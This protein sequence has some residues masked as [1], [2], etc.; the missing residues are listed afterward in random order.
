MDRF[1]VLKHY[2]GYDAFRQGQD[3]LIEHLLNGEDVVGI[4]PT[5]AGKS[6]CF[7]VPALLFSGLTLV[8]S[9]LISLMKDQVHSLMQTGVN[10][11]CINGTLSWFEV[12]EIMKNCVLGDTKILYVAPE[13]LLDSAFLSFIDQLEISLL[14]VD[15]AHCVSQWGQDFRPS[16]LKI[17]QFLSLLK[18]RPIVG[19]FTATATKEVRTDIIE[20]LELQSPKIVTTGFNRDNLYFE[21]QKLKDKFSF[22]RSYIEGHAKESGIIYCNTRK[23]VDE[24]CLRLQVIGFPVTKY[25]AGLSA[26][27]RRRNQEDFLFDCKPIIIATNAFGMGI[28]KSNVAYVIHYNMPKNIESYYQEAGRAGRGGEP[29]ECILLYQA[30]DVRTNQYFIDHTRENDELDAETL[31]WVKEKERER[32]KQMTFYCHTNDCLR[33][34]ILKYFGESGMSYCGNCSNC[35]QNYDQVER[36]IEAQK[37]LSCIRRAKSY[38][39]ESMIIDCLCGERTDSI[40][41]AGLHLLSTFG[42]LSDCAN[43]TV[44]QLIWQLLNQSYLE[45]DESNGNLLH[46]TDKGIA[47][48]VHREQFFVPV[49]KSVSRASIDDKVVKVA[50]EES[51]MNPALFERLKSIRAELA[52]EQKVPAFVIFSD[53]SL[54]E[55]SA[56][57]PST[58]EEFLMISGVGKM[59]LER[60]G[61]VFL[62]VIQRYTSTVNP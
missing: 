56:K 60:Y 11:A 32:L 41:K 3:V 42:L 61:K 39:Y 13:R 30:L 5:G 18:K 22:I 25:H 2:F 50:K 31:E 17:H 48:L 54:R 14:A 49:K 38:A 33:G 37:I 16:Y 47:F 19:A 55:M 52:R 53:A 20:I 7:Q 29:G 9:P 24:L 43:T 44:Q 15:E 6:I 34:Y 10:A 28:D 23:N 58:E 57:I 8:I 45:R 46:V 35:K 21:V 26:D 51:S 36:T 62:P 40:E 4:M 12:Q 59:K 1:Q 27:E